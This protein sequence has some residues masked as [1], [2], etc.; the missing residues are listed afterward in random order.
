MSDVLAEVASLSSALEATDIGQRLLARPRY[1][2]FKPADASVDDWEALLDCDVNNFR[3]NALT[4]ALG[5]IIC[6]YEEVSE[7]VA[8]SV[9]ITAAVHDIPEIK[10]GNDTSGDIP[11]GLCTDA[12]TDEEYSYLQLL[13]FD[14]DCPISAEVAATAEQTMADS[15]SERLTQAGELFWLTEKLG[16][17]RSAVIAHDAYKKLPE[18]DPTRTSL[19]CMWTDIFGNSYKELAESYHKFKSV[20]V[21][22]ETNLHQL[23]EMYALSLKHLE[24]AKNFYETTVMPGRTYDVE[25]EL[26][27][28]AA[29][30]NAHT[31]MADTLSTVSRF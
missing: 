13:G 6:Q 17:F 5:Y 23:E 25:K 21:F 22:F 20:A 24:L 1:G 8:R 16:Y 7:S 3:H 2:A 27:K 29:G 30:Y 10:T 31:Q 26:A 19:L 12:D 11:L 14:E 4:S 9:A 18:D 28:I 15:K